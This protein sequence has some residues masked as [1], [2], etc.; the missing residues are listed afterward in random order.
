MKSIRC[1]AWRFIHPDFDIEEGFGTGI[2][3]SNTGGIEMVEDQ[4]AVRQAIMLLLT[5]THGERVMRPE[6]G[7]DLQKL[8]FSPN[9]ATTH[10]LA[11][12]YV[13]RA[14]QKWEPRI[15]ILLLDAEASEKDPG[16]MNILLEYRVRKTGR[17]DNL[18]FS[19]SLTGEVD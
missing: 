9:D 7:C 11:I 3:I 14:L 17:S 1:R 2:R 16:R 15:D 4:A 12:Y 10:G 19:V 18:N 13:R 8:I 5:T 6:Y